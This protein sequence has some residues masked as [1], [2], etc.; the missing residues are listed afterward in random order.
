MQGPHVDRG[1]VT[2]KLTI[3]AGQ[4]S[5]SPHQVRQKLDGAV[6]EVRIYGRALPAAQIAALAGAAASRAAR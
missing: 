6:D 2:S 4:F 3:G 1:P 5:P